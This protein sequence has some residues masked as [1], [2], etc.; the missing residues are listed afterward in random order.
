MI[1][2]AAAGSFSRIMQLTALS[3]DCTK[4]VAGNSVLPRTDSPFA[5]STVAV[6][7]QGMTARA[8]ARPAKP[9]A[10]AAVK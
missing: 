2:E 10:K 4:A 5:L 1:S 3:V 7:F 6:T 8:A 9:T